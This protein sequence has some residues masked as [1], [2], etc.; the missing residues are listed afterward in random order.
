MNPGQ[1][2]R[3]WINN[4]WKQLFKVVTLDERLCSE[5]LKK[6]VRT[7]DYMFWT[8]A[9][10][11]VIR[12]SGSGWDQWRIHS[13]RVPLIV[14]DFFVSLAT[15]DSYCGVCGGPWQGFTLEK[16]DCSLLV[17]IKQCITVKSTLHSSGVLCVRNN[18]VFLVVFYVV[19]VVQKFDFRLL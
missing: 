4:K 12:A 7:Q 8:W 10:V 19:R 11:E 9:V 15:T 16:T 5:G 17:T 13:F 18:T 14:G 3:R 1:C 2:W 6:T